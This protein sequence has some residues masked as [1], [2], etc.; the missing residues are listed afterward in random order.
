MGWRRPLL[1][2]W[3]APWACRRGA[4]PRT[5]TSGTRSGAREEAGLV[6]AT[7]HPKVEKLAGAGPIR[8]RRI[9]VDPAH[10]IHLPRRRESMPRPGR[11][12]ARGVMAQVP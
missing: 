6:A 1:H 9:A 10:A 2:R 8:H 4:S 7:S 3:A 5:P 12:G 11:W